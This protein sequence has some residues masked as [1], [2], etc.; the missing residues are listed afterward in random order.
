[1]ALYV[2]DGVLKNNED[3]WKEY[4]VLNDELD[5]VYEISVDE[6]EFILT[7][8]LRPE[9]NDILIDI[10]NNKKYFLA[11]REES[12]SVLY[13]QDFEFNIHDEINDIKVT[14]SNIE[15]NSGTNESE[16]YTENG[17]RLI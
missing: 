15:I 14:V 2:E 6:D 7:E 3:I 16:D 12:E 5:T 13:L 1:M 11:I 17:W 4:R 10:N 9:K 8:I